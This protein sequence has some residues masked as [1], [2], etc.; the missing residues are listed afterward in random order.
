MIR[1]AIGETFL[2]R[3]VSEAQLETAGN[4]PMGQQKG[5]VKILN[6]IVAV[7]CNNLR[8]HHDLHRGDR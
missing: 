1:G 8:S 6:P 7:S 4:M 5:L 2:F 3:N